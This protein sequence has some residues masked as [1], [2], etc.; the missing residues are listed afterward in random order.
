MRVEILHVPDCPSVP[1]L[2]ERLD[3]ALADV[4]IDVV[5]RVVRDAET[6]AAVGMTGSPT[7]LVDGVDPFAEPGV[8]PSVSCR[9]YRHEDGH[10][11]GAPSVARLRD[12]LDRRRA[13]VALRDWR[14][15]AAPADPAERAV[16]QAILRSFA[17]TG[18]PPA[19]VDQVA[20]SF[21]ETG[22]QVLARL[23]D[24]DVIRVD[25]AGRVQ[26]AYPFSAAPT[27]HRVRLAGGVEVYA[28]C[29]IDALGMPAMLG[30]DAV[31]ATTDPTNGLPITVTIAAGRAQWDPPGAVVFVGARP[32]GG[33]SAEN[34]CD[35]LNVF[36]DRA[37]AQ[38]WS[39]AHPHIPGEILDGADAE[40]LGRRIFGGLLAR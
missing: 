17:A 1:V 3:Q 10:L 24:A 2:R 9:L 23:H 18:A 15:R 40:A 14:A 39:R 29:A 21:A 5:E 33:P 22:D 35:A 37:S 26:V 6:A 11:D 13:S 20:G 34:C 30:A 8:A 19:T 32:G 27:A 36:T 38:T 25:A 4:V 16:H 28:M 7:L 31:I 12:A